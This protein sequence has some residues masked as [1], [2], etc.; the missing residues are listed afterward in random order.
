[1]PMLDGP[2]TSRYYQH[3]LLSATFVRMPNGK[4]DY[5][6]ANRLMLQIVDDPQYSARVSKAQAKMAQDNQRSWQKIR[7]INAKGIAER[8]KMFSDSQARISQIRNETSDIISSTQIGSSDYIMREQTE[9]T[10]GFE[11]YNDPINGGTVELDS[12]YNHAW[13]LNDGSFMLSN[14]ANFNPNVDLSLDATNLQ[15]TQ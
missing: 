15:V 9:A 12:N 7:Q 3:A 4:L 10:L 11:T 5:K 1:M 8:S 13:Q 2:V 14:D 6:M